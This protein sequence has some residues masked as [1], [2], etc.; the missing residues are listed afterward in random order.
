MLTLI[1]SSLILS[2]IMMFINHPLS[3]T[4]S[5][6]MQAIMV[7]MITGPMNYDFW[8]SYIMF[9]I[10]IGGM[11]VV[12]IYMTSIASNEKFKMNKTWLIMTMIILIPSVNHMFNMNNEDSM[13]ITN[14]FNN[15]MSMIKYYSWPMN[16]MIMMLIMYLLITLIAI[17][18][19][20][21]TKQGPLRQF[22]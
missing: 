1:I 6:I 19:I 21:L 11:L 16:M 22:K 7:A 20:T 14:H 17:V 8:F 13:T 18:K 2:L 10:M 4:M 15:Q 3:M 12:F 9:M 5:L